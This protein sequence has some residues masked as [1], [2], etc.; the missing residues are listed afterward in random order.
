MTL[1]FFVASI[2]YSRPETMVLSSAIKYMHCQSRFKSWLPQYGLPCGSFITRG[3][4]TYNLEC[5]SH[6]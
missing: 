1:N 6:L 4:I 5:N 3:M 2:I